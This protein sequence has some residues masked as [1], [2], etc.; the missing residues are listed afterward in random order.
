[1]LDPVLIA[2]AR[3]EKRKRDEWARK[4]ATENR[5]ERYLRELEGS[6]KQHHR[7]LFAVL[8]VVFTVY[9]AILSFFIWLVAFLSG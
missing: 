8:R 9:M 7:A 1:L 2:K 4:L 3:R 5:F 6:P